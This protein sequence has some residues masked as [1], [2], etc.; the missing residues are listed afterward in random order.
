MFD[1]VK[2]RLPHRIQGTIIL[3]ERDSPP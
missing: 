3:D 1:K 2:K